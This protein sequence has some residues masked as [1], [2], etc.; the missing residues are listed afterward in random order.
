MIDD[1]DD[2][3]PLNSRPAPFSEL[4]SRGEIINTS[5]PYQFG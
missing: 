5:F 2:E 3:H 4:G 1:D